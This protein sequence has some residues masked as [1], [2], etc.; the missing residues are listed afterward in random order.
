MKV[1][2]IIFDGFEEEEAVAPFALLKRA[3][4]ELDI[5]SNTT[6]VRGTHNIYLSEIKSI[7]QSKFII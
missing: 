6:T 7:N 3:G 2:A 5:A 4:A 1:L